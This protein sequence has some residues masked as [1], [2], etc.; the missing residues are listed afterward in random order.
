[1]PGFTIMKEVVNADLFPHFAFFTQTC[2]EL[3]LLD[4]YFLL[5]LVSYGKVV[6]G[7]SD[8]ILTFAVEVLNAK[9]KNVNTCLH[10]DDLKPIVGL[11]V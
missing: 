11:A 8:L 9:S 1:V 7:D 5:S 10:I 6:A 4:A 3:K 2:F